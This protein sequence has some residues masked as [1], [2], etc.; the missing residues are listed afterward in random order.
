MRFLHWLGLTVYA[1]PACSFVLNSPTAQVPSCC[2]S[3][4]CAPLL[5]RAPRASQGDVVCSMAV[6]AADDLDLYTIKELEDYA[7]PWGVSLSMSKTGPF[8]RI[9]ARKNLDP[10]DSDEDGV[11]GYTSGFTLGDLIHLDTVQIKRKQSFV[12]DTEIRSESP[13]QLG[14]LLGSYAMCHGRDQGCTRAE[15]LA[16]RDFD[17]QYIRLVRYYKIGGFQEVREVTDDISS[18]PDRLVW[19][20]CGLLMEAPIDVYMKRWTTL[21]RAQNKKLGTQ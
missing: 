19:G 14:A 3:H 6:D 15:L 12:L 8:Y 17:Q 1:A 5:T 13:F 21:I 11:V 4:T 16:I 20:G 10:E 2:L 9:E 7:R 18:V